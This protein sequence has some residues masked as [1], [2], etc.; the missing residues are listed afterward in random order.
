MGGREGNSEWEVDGWE[1][2]E[3]Q[4]KMVWL[5]GLVKSPEE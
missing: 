3:N 4:T 5:W 1:R 2:D